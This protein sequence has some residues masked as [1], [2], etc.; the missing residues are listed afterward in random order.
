MNGRA[1]LP[2]AVEP[3]RHASEGLT[4]HPVAPL[5]GDGPELTEEMALD[6]RVKRI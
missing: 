5:K 4:M 2:K 1:V 6:Q 3:G